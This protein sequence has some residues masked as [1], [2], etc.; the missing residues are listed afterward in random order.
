MELL[1]I[2]LIAAGLSGWVFIASRETKKGD[3]II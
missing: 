3:R 1:G 2:M